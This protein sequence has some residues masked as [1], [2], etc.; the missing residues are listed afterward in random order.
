MGSGTNGWDLKQPQKKTKK[1]IHFNWELINGIS[2]NN[3]VT[4][5]AKVI[6]GWIVQTN[7]QLQYISSVFIPDPKH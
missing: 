1:V 5:R 6:G 2:G 7:Y 4:Y 3:E